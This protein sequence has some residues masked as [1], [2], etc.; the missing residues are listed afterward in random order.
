MPTPGEAS[1]GVRRGRRGGH[2][3]IVLHEGLSVPSCAGWERGR[4]W[5]DARAHR[6]FLQRVR[7]RQLTCSA[8]VSPAA[9]VLGVGE[10][11]DSGVLTLLLQQPGTSGLQAR[12][13]EGLWVDVPPLPGTL[14]VNIGELLQLATGALPLLMPLSSILHC[15]ETLPQG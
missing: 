15:R 7:T 1:G 11:S 9:G 12:N 6:A 5:C 13:S 3:G 8:C 4:G 2:A 14:V 10:H